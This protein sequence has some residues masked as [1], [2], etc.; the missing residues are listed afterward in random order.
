MI[1]ED[2][3][4][5]GRT[6]PEE[7]RKYGHRVCMAG[8]S[9]ELNQLMRVYPLQVQNPIRCRHRYR[10]ELDRNSDDSRPESW[11]LRSERVQE[12]EA[13]PFDVSE[14][15]RC[16]FE[17]I[18]ELNRRKLSLG[19]LRVD[20]VR[21]EFVARSD[22]PQHDQ[23]TLFEIDDGRAF[24]ARAVGLMPYLNFHDA[25]G[26]PHRLQIREWGCYEWVRK[27]PGDAAGLWRNLQL[28]RPQLLVVGN[29]NNRR[30]AWLVI[31]SFAVDAHDH[32]AKL[33]DTEPEPSPLYA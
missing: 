9:R 31:K 26:R 29:M 21:G 33:F 16:C 14:L 18:D 2:F 7:S 12:I 32:Q 15:E 27:R 30:T 13:A 24:G 22:A 11:K 6:V 25:A 8:Y 5:L 3:T 1:C 17:S 19:V 4:C 23:R 20:S 10:L 28:H